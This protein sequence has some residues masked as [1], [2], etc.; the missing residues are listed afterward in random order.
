MNRHRQLVTR[1]MALGAAIALFVIE[2][3]PTIRFR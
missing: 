1:L 3:A 2:A